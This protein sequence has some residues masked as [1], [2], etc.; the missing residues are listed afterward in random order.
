MTNPNMTGPIIHDA[1]I[2]MLKSALS[3]EGNT[4]DIKVLSDRPHW[5]ALQVACQLTSAYRVAELLREL[6]GDLG[7]ETRE[8][9]ALALRELLLNAVEHGGH[10]DPEK[11]VDLSYIR[12]P[13]SV[14]CYIRDPGE[15]FSFDS[16]ERSAI[17]NDAQQLFRQLELRA[18]QGMRPGGLGIL[19]AKRV[20]DDL[21]YSA[22][23]NEV[24]FIKYL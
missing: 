17:S 15:G 18:Q 23:G 14:V 10:L 24:M 8:Q 16:L 1:P 20:A 13:R 21:I 4:G 6:L 12:T 5:V 2:T 3:A 11:T 7:P 22:K 9:I 19:L